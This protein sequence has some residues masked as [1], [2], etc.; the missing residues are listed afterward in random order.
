MKSSDGIKSKFMEY[1]IK[2]SEV[3][4]KYELHQTDSLVKKT[5]DYVLNHVEENI[6]LKKIAKEV[7]ASKDYIG[8]LFKQK[9]GCNFNQYVTKIKMEHVKYLIKLG[10]YKNYE[11][12]EK[13][14]YSNT[15]YFCCLFK[16]YTG[17]TPENS[18]KTI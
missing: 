17:Y 1:I 8:K 5:C 18:G 9:T 15:D 12:S 2:M 16:K 10:S 13:L 11:V 6:S 14:G 7:H 3:I 4:G